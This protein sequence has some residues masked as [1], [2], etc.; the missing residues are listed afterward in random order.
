M[1][2]ISMPEVVVI[3]VIALIVIGPK[4]LPD[5][6]RAL[7]RGLAEFRKATQEIKES[8]AVD[9]DIKSVKDDI[10]DSVSGFNGPKAG[11]RPAPPSA[12]PDS[13]RPEVAGAP[14][15][16]SRKQPEAAKDEPSEQVK[17]GS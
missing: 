4:K 3:L 10:I 14:A 6:A 12:G 1:F 7:G 5:L 2:G 16:D 8:L 9:E 11:K 17:N 13:A 15:G